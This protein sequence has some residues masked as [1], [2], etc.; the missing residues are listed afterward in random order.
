MLDGEAPPVAGDVPVQFVVI[1]E[2]SQLPVRGIAYRVGVGAAA[3]VGVLVSDI[4]A[5]PVVETLRV[6]GFGIAVFC[7]VL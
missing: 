5:N 1:P 2:K 4:N 7:H 3:E 6:V